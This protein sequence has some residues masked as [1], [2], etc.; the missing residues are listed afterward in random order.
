MAVKAV[1]QD[2]LVCRDFLVILCADFEMLFNQNFFR[3]KPLIDHSFKGNYL[4]TDLYFIHR[5]LLLYLE[6]CISCNHAKEIHCSVL[7]ISFAKRSQW[8]LV[9]GENDDLGFCKV[10]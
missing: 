6:A 3:N 2:Y 1:F 10:F 7:L 4:T 8:E 9:C 5:G